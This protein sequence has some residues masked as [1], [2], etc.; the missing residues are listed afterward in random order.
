M[1]RARWAALMIVAVALSAT[2]GCSAP[3]PY[4][5]REAEFDRKSKNFNK[6]PLN[7]D[8]VIICYNKYGTKPEI[9]ANMAGAECARYNK[10]A[11]FV[12]QS[13]RTCPLTTPVAAEF[14]CIG[15]W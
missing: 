3:G 4:V 6:T 10:K 15:G 12:R 13:Y 11:E 14:D 2:A 8:S 9:V 5:Y 1:T 7:I